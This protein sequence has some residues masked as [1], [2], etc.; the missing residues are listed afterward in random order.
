MSSLYYNMSHNEK[1]FTPLENK[2]FISV[3]RKFF[4]NNLPQI[5][6][7]VLSYFVKDLIALIEQYYPP[8]T[9]LKMGQLLW[10]A[11]SADETPGK[12]KSMC[13]TRVV[14]VILTL[15]DPDD[16]KDLKNNVPRHIVSQNIIARL[17]RQAKQQGGVLT[18]AEIALFRNL[19]HTAIGKQTLAY[20][21]LHN[22]VLPRRGTVHDLG[23]SVSHKKTICKKFI[24]DKET[25]SNIS[26]ETCH[27]TSSINRYLNDFNR[28]LLCLKKGLKIDEIS[29]AAQISKKVVNDYLDI[30]EGIDYDLP[31]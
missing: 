17:Y 28:V 3:L 23:P 18:E 4:L 15:V 9:H 20:E 29:F 27:S 10:F 31:F 19:T 5:G 25:I 11:V 13:D 8:L 26:S 6:D 1:V 22:T 21:K 12:H 16:I 30:I 14:P 2:S 7:A 24:I